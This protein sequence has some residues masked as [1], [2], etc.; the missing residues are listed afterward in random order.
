[1]RFQRQ[2]ECFGKRENLFAFDKRH[3]VVG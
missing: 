3:L 1:V 2:L